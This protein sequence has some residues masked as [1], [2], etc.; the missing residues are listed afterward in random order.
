MTPWRAILSAATLAGA[1]LGCSTGGPA[2]THTT[3]T[4]PAGAQTAN[5]LADVRATLNRY[6]DALRDGDFDAAME[7]RCTAGRRPAE[8]E[9]LF[10][11][12]AQTLIDAGAMTSVE[13]ARV[14]DVR[15]GPVER[16]ADPI[17]FDYALVSGSK[18]SAWLHGVA[19]VQDGAV[20]FCGY[21][22]AD[23]ATMTAEL[24]T[25]PPSGQNRIQAP[26]ELVPSE[27]PVAY[28]Q[29]DDRIVNEPLDDVAGWQSAWTRAW[30]R[31]PSGG[32]RVTV[33]RFD[34]KSSAA[35]GLTA[36]ALHVSS[37]ATETFTVDAMPNAV[38]MRYAAVA[39]TWMQPA[40]V[41]YQCDQVLA[42]YGP[43]LAIV[44]SCGLTPD[45]THQGVID[46]AL[47]VDRAG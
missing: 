18:R 26:R 42:L 44:S 23:I 41:G 15:I 24:G 19:I 17:D 4:Q 9:D 35:A 34:S 3:A 8:D 22:Q 36:M 7:E 30:Q 5:E 25:A 21:G 38:G 29:I 45:E 14:S 13:V 27:G 46:L 39:W 11:A 32:A 16:S 2:A 31:H 47:A 43:T 20:R 12:Q 28:E 40:N 33:A 1:L 37:D 6:L 10:V